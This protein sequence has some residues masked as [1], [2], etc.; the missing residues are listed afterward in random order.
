[1]SLWIFER[2]EI[3][4]RIFERNERRPIMRSD[5]VPGGIFPNYE[6]SDHT[7]QCPS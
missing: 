3:Q 1:V 2:E 7:A 5:T 4:K 6:L